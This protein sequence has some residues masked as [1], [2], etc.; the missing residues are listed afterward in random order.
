MIEIKPGIFLYEKELTFHAVRSG[1]AGGQHVNKVSTKVVL[2]YPIEKIQGLSEKQVNKVRQK[3]ST[4]VV[5]NHI[6]IS[7]Q[8]H[9]SQY[10]NKLDTIQ[11]L[12]S[13]LINALKENKPRVKTKV[14]KSAV[15]KRLNKKKQKSDIKKSRNLKNTED[16]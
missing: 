16:I 8:K 15:E 5:E 10:S 13:L 14:P 11:K 4:Y 3:L 1:G 6:Q 2:K 9:R 12:E 7:S